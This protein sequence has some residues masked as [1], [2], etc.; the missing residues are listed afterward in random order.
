MKTLWAGRTIFKKSVN[1]DIN[2]IGHTCVSGQPW[3][4]SHSPSIM[5]ICTATERVTKEAIGRG[6]SGLPSISIEHGHDLTTSSGVKKAW[7]HYYKHRPDV[8]VLAWPCD[9]WSS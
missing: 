3:D 1:D 5:E 2:Y 8:V 7:E 9:P 4:C 6:W